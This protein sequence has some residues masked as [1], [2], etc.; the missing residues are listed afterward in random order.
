MTT[1][2][3]SATARSLPLAALGAACLIAVA[4]FLFADL[5][6]NIG[7]VLELRATQLLVF[8]QVAVSVGVATVLFQTVTANRILTPAIMGM[9]VL[10]LLCQALMIVVLGALGLAGMDARLKFGLEL[11]A[12]LGLALFIFLPLLRRT[13]DMGLLLLTG[14]VLGLLFHSL[15]SLFLRL[16]DPNDFAVYQ[17]ASFADFSDVPKDLLWIGCIAAVAGAIIAWRSRHVLDVL[18]LGP[19]SAIALGVD[20]RRMVTALLVLVAVLTAT[21]TALVG[22]LNFLGLLAVAL[23][24]RVANTRRHAVLLPAAILMALTILV[25][26]QVVLKH[27]FGNATFLSVVVEFFGGIVFLLL[28]FRS[29][30]R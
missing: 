7:F 21:S 20:W 5:R 29:R 28:L 6:G 22:P 17:G 18:S 2:S 26:G 15:T 10:Y 3:V 14:V 9:D 27:G 12:M 24:E 30:L 11:A 16:A 19:E 8:A 4:A 13:V 1:A 25:G 23:A